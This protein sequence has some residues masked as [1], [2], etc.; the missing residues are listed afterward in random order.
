MSPTILEFV[1]FCNSICDCYLVNKLVGESFS[2]SFNKNKFMHTTEINDTE[3]FTQRS[4]Y[5]CIGFLA[6]KKL[7]FFYHKY[8]HMIITPVHKTSAKYGPVCSCPFS[9]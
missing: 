1:D 9:R 8:T 7:F 5:A 2:I 6:K 3:H 4:P